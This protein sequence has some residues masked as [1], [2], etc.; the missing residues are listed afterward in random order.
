MICILDY[1]LFPLETFYLYNIC[2]NLHKHLPHSED[3]SPHTNTDRCCK[4]PILS[5]MH[6]FFL[7]AVGT[8]MCQLGAAAMY[9]GALVVRYPSRKDVANLTVEEREDIRGDIM[10]LMYIREHTLFI[11]QGLIRNQCSS[12]TPIPTRYT[13]G[14]YLQS[15]NLK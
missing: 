9:L 2:L 7:A 13:V 5:T 11:C 3:M 10:V 14:N 8:L 15:E 6:Y 12:P 1:V 4:E